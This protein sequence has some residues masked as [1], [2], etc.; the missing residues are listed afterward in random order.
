MIYDY[1]KGSGKHRAVCERPIGA[2]PWASRAGAVR[3]AIAT[4]TASAASGV[5]RS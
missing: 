3:T 2:S 4:A 1:Y 5:G